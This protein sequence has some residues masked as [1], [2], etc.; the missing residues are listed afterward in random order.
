[1]GRASEIDEGPSESDLERFGSE[2]RECPSCGS[3]VY[4]QAEICQACGHAF[5]RRDSG[6][7][8]W[9]IV[10]GVL[11]IAAFVLLAVL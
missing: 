3:L 10:A 1:M 11:V 4:D 2:F 8:V 7:P 9:A 5:M 6:L